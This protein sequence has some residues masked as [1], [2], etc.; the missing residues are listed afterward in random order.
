MAES[1]SRGARRHRGTGLGRPKGW[2]T[3]F[4]SLV[5][6]PPCS[7]TSLWSRRLAANNADVADRSM[8]TLAREPVEVAPALHDP[9]D[10]RHV[11]TPRKPFEREQRPP[12]AKRDPRPGARVPA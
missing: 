7:R 10:H 3:L 9:D 5:P 11:V 12:G 6:R 4:V 2:T 1:R 8:E